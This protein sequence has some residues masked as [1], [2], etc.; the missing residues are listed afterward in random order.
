M[1]LNCTISVFFKFGACIFL[2]MIKHHLKVPTKMLLNRAE[3]FEKD[4]RST[5]EYIPSKFISQGKIKP[6]EK[7]YQLK[8]IIFKVLMNLL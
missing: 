8:R 6:T 7:I 3:Y 1:I 5:A 2:F 4:R